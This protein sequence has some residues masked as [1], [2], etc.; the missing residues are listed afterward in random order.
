MR[1]G[2]LV[3]GRVT[4]EGAFAY[5]LTRTPSDTTWIG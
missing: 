5:R 3:V 4:R 2:G 1:A